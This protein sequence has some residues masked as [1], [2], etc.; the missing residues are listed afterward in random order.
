MTEQKNE[1]Y[2]Q[3]QSLEQ[4]EGK[5]DDALFVSL[6]NSM[7]NVKWW[8]KNGDCGREYLA[9]KYFNEEENNYSLFY[10]EWLIQMKDGRLG[11]FDVK[12]DKGDSL[13]ST[14]QQAKALAKRIEEMNAFA[15]SNLFFGGFIVKVNEDWYY[16]DSMD[17]QPYS[18]NPEAWKPFASI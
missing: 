8:F 10:P 4:N 7:Q 16:N 9:V 12:I 6:L 14:K 3:N 15:K 13:A 18:D 1:L 17:Y 11:I 2:L 5:G